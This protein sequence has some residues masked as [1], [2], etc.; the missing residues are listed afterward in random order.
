MAEIF[1]CAN[2]TP[3]KAWASVCMRSD[4]SRRKSDFF[5]VPSA[6]RKQMMAPIT[7]PMRM[8]SSVTPNVCPA[9]CSSAAC[10]RSHSTI[11]WRTVSASSGMY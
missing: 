11:V 2:T 6:S 3:R 10:S 7:M 5:A 1:T 4:A 8:W 9:C